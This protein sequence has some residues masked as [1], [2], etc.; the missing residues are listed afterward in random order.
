MKPRFNI[1][2][3]I[4]TFFL[5]ITFQN[6]VATNA[7]MKRVS[8]DEFLALLEN[9]EITEVVLG[10]TTM[11]GITSVPEGETPQIFVTNRVE[12]DAVKFL[13]PYDVK[14]RKEVENTFFRDILSWVIPPLIFVFIWIYFLKK[15][16]Q[17]GGGGPG[18]SLMS[19]GKS[20]AKVYVE[21][22]TGKTFKDVAG[23]D[24]AKRELEEIVEFLKD[25]E[26]YGR[27]GGRM[28]KGI[29]L[30]GPPGTGKTLLAKAIAG[31]AGVP[32]FSISGSEFVEMF[33]GVGAAR[34]RDLFNQARK[35]SPCI[36]FIDELDALG[37]SR[38]SSNMYGGNDEKEQT[39]NQLLTEMDG[40]E[41]KEGIILLG[42]TNRPEIL[43][44]ALLRAGRFDRQVLVDRP[45][46]GGRLEIL[47]VHIQR[48]KY[49]KD[50]DLEQIASL[51]T[52]FT[53]AD[54]E[55]LVNEAALVAT[56]KD[57]KF[58]ELQDFT[59]ATE[60][61]VAGLEKTNR[62]LNDF[63]RTVVAHHEMG[64][65]IMGMALKSV[66]E[67]HKIS[68]IPRGM[69]ALG[70]TI[71]RPSEDRFLMRKE[72][73]EAKI[74]VLMGGRVAEKII[75]NHLSTGA[76]DDL[77][78]ATDIARSM[79]T[80]YGMVK[81][82]GHVS[83]ERTQQQFLGPDGMKTHE[84]SEETAREIDEAVKLIV[85]NA[86]QRTMSILTNNKTLLET[87]A[88]ELLKKE[89]LEGEDL[90]SIRDSITL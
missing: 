28:P 52:G 55:N 62:L 9:K 37:K 63:E 90:N 58:V 76:S 88:A 87:S 25:K 13:K 73:L 75:F 48:I 31:E 78:K 54:L 61:I 10:E 77:A 27:L 59:Q 33:V 40:F 23:V 49:K 72:E 8:Y 69:G 41:T 60:R 36:I 81:Q 35:S 24:E 74:C 4:I 2:P 53:G 42:A 29:L 65:A 86:Y 20:K 14:F 12:E 84:Y 11:K 6:L 68:I 46:K 15:M 51:T 43:D 89:T 17:K 45:D 1:W 32:F 3:L 85:E 16:A 26:K 21:K 50:L 19:V 71:Q 83:L 22:N 57:K 67:V 79:V 39:L 56:R 34:V 70:Y 30:V 64:H 7:T 44:P 38:G 66:D 47:R 80:K 18:G 82:L 5:V